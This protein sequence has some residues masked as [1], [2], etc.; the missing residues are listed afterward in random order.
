MTEMTEIP[1]K[2]FWM[3]RD[4]ED[5]SREELIEVVKQLGRDLENTRSFATSSIRTMANL[6]HASNR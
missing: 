5:M 3:G 6:V 2:T 4:I 1:M